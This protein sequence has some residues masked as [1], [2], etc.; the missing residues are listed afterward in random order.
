MDDENDRAPVGPLGLRPGDPVRLKRLQANKSMNG[1]VGYFMKLE[2]AED[3]GRYVVEL[4]KRGPV[5]VR[6]INVEKVGPTRRS[7]RLAAREEAADQD[8]DPNDLDADPE[9]APSKN[10]KRPAPAAKAASR[11]AKARPKAKT[12]VKKPSHGSIF[13]Y[14]CSACRGL[15]LIFPGSFAKKT[16]APKPGSLSRAP[17]SFNVLDYRI[18]SEP[19]LEV[20]DAS[21][22]KWRPCHLYQSLRDGRIVIWYGGSEGTWWL[23]NSLRIALRPDYFYWPCW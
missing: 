5:R 14:H 12:T 23:R 7:E 17:A 10:K 1:L 15:T 19:S 20:Q 8:P 18:C 16:A 2:T 13:P 6:E 21:Q 3:G 22:M 9:A 11:A 4:G